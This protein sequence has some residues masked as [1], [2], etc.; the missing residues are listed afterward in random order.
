MHN[1]S[2]R[3]SSFLFEVYFSRCQRENSFLYLF[4]SVRILALVGILFSD[5]W[6]FFLPWSS[7]FVKEG[8]IT[9][10]RHYVSSLFGC[11]FLALHFASQISCTVLFFIYL[12][13]ARRRDDPWAH[14]PRRLRCI[15]FLPYSSASVS[16]RNR[17]NS[18][19]CHQDRSIPRYALSPPQ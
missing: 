13:A 4:L 18:A 7:H 17:A 16:S 9:Q 12:Q 1:C 10:P 19:H 3:I 2:V 14:Q 6:V 8:K 11:C 5:L 15:C